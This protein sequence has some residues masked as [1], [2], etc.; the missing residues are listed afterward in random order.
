[1][2]VIEQTKGLPLKWPD[3][4]W[5][6]TEGKVRR[7]QERIFRAAQNGEHA[8]VK[9]L[10]KLL[11]RSTAA[12]LL[13]TRQVTQQ[14]RG[15]HTPGVDGVIV[16]TPEARV[17]LLQ[18]GLNLKGYRPLPVRRVHIPKANGKTR[19][20]GIPTVKDRVMQAIVKFAL[21]PEWESRFEANSYGFRPGRST[22]DAN[23][24]IH[25]TLNKRG[26]SEWV[27]DADISGCFDNIS[28]DALL[29]RLPVF[30]KVV[31]RWL[32]A[33]VVEFGR[34]S[35][36]LA[37]TPQGG[38]ISPL[39]ANIALDGLERL[40]GAEDVRGNL[41][42]P[43]KRKG[44]NRGL[45]VIRYADDFVVTAPSKE[46]LEE[47][48]I[49]RITDFLKLRGL[50]LSEAKTRIVH[51]DEGFD[52]LGYTVR[53][54]KG[55]LLT[56]PA[57]E[58]VLSHLRRVKAYLKNHEQTPAGQVIRDL[59]PVIR[60]WANYYRH[61]AA[62]GTFDKADHRTWQMLWTWAK[63]RHPNKP[64]KWIKRRYFRNDGVWT[65]HEGNAQLLRR[66][67][68]SITRFKKVEGKASKLDPTLRAYWSDRKRREMARQI[69]QKERLQLLRQQDGMC[70]FCHLPLSTEDIDDHHIHPRHAGGQNTLDNRILVHRWCHHAHHQRIGYKSKKA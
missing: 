2:L 31:R 66:S 8:K 63:R 41:V 18:E 11:V 28:H 56:L 25:T 10:Q 57:K 54:F 12:K 13:A 32:K 40:F 15:K 39:L 55:K 37:G 16:D 46:V 61:T 21:E 43:A 58:K 3:I 59:N 19:P 14:N 9:N 48:V 7:I 30:T 5:T 53:R 49:P 20:L 6:A 4:N 23:V 22:M 52:F 17:Q 70:G 35:D 62:K 33:G 51:I 27:L 1:M 69:I 29:N 47:Y 60:G 68:I 50:E 64:T 26:C 38:I 36:S 24:A 67:I 42:A 44:L 34:M 45:S 65:F